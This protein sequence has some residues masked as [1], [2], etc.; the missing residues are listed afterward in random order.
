MGQMTEEQ[1][2]RFSEAFCYFDRDNDGL[3]T[4]KELGITMRSL[5]ENVSE[6]EVQEMT[7]AMGKDVV[8]LQTFLQMMER[9]VT[10]KNTEEELLKA[11]RFFDRNQTGNI[12]VG[13]LRHLLTSI[14]EKLSGDEFD[15]WI[16]Q[17][18][19]C[20]SNGR[21]AFEQLVKKLIVTK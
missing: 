2:S 10:E 7:S 20:D 21:I 14:G 8:D 5:G 12:Y 13:E 6:E 11:F 15:Q 3:I 4:N 17:D 16:D 9:R 1:V 19:D 18:K